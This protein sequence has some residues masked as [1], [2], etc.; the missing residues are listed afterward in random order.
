VR[1]NE[2]ELQVGGMQ[3]CESLHEPEHVWFAR[4]GLD[5]NGALH[6]QVLQVGEPGGLQQS[7]SSHVVGQPIVGRRLGD[8][9]EPE[10]Q[11]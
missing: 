10:V 7:V 2:S 9:N 1:T 11:A 8:F 4:L 5:V 3:H 6:D